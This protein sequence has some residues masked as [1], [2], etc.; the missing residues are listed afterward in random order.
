[1]TILPARLA[2]LGIILPLLASGDDDLQQS[3]A[4]WADAATS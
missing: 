3:S 1:M 4:S 2:L